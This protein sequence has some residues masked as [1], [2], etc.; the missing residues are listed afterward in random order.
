MKDS[1]EI[2]EI[3]EILQS[4]V[5]DVELRKSIK[6]IEEAQRDFLLAE[7]SARLKKSDALAK[8]IMRLDRERIAFGNTYALLKDSL[9]PEV[10]AKIQLL[11]DRLDLQRKRYVGE[12]TALIGKMDSSFRLPE[13]DN[14]Y[15]I[16]LQPGDILA[17]SRK[18]GVYQHFAVYIGDRRVIHY[19]AE[20]GDF[21]GRI[22]IH[23]APF[24][25]FKLES[26]FVYVLDFPEESGQPSGRGMNRK[27]TEEDALFNYIRA[28]GYHLFSPQETIERA[29]S[30]LGEEK[31]SLPFNNCEHFAIWCKTNVKES[32]QVNQWITRL[33]RAVNMN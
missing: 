32:H 31:Y 3:I 24:E 22:S 27:I 11:S 15:G 17:V 14:Y 13:Q 5:A 19:A 8:A 12:K 6:R 16:P 29:K 33:Y 28:A 21:S 23:E 7:A 10:H 18:G 30:R 2:N 4:V 9:S 25:E 26:T 1:N 20:Q